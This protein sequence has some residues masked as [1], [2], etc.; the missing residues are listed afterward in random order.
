MA[1]LLTG[2]AGY[3]GSHCYYEFLKLNQKLVVIDNLSTGFR[4]SLPDDALFFEGDVGDEDLLN[5]IFKQHDIKIVVHFAGSLVV[6]E[7]VHNPEK[8][9]LNNVTNSIKLLKACKN[10]NVNNIIFSSTASVYGSNPKQIM[11]ESEPCN[12]E[13]P[14]AFSKLIVENLIQDYHRAYGLNYIILR[15]FNVAGADIDLKTGQKTKNASHL[16]KVGVELATEKRSEMYI[17][18]TDYPTPDGSCIRDYIHVNDLANAHK[19]S[20]EYLLENNNSVN[21]IFN[22]GYGKGYSVKEV[23]NT[24]EK[25]TGK[26][27]NIKDA[28]RRAGDPVALTADSSKIKKTL[29]WKPKHD[30]LEFILNSALKWEQKYNND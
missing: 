1:I 30:D 10:N 28:P 27:L 9:Y 15:Y 29:D 18:G 25:I 2:G 7:S 17:Y 19:K 13:N 3:I 20:I 12:P 23:L 24:L 4:D 16:I 5:S 21:K 14:Y 8:Y 22:C 6:E 11:T 26:T